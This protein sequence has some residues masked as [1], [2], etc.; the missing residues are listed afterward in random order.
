M[1]L[2][3]QIVAKV[4]YTIQA[5]HNVAVHFMAKLQNHFHVGYK[6]VPSFRFNHRD[7]NLN[8]VVS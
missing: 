6:K 7:W 4:P 8:P 3:K 5:I 1:S 2:G